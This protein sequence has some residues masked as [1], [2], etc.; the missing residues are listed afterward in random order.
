[1]LLLGSEILFALEHTPAGFLQQRLVAVL[2]HLSGFGGTDLI[3]RLIHLG[4]DMK[5]IQN[6]Q[7]LRTFVADHIQVGLPHIGAN[8]FDARSE[9][10]SDDGEETL[11]RSEEHT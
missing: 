5:T 11:E 8:K 6:M 10:I 2:G 7:R 9:W 1:M 4:H 3:Q